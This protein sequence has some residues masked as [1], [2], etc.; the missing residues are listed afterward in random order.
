[1][2]EKTRQ[3][4]AE[5]I[6]RRREWGA[7]QG[8]LDQFKRLSYLLEELC[9]DRQ[10]AN[11]VPTS[12]Q[13]TDESMTGHEHTGDEPVLILSVTEKDGEF[14]G[15]LQ[16]ILEQFDRRTAKGVQFSSNIGSTESIELE[17]GGHRRNPEIVLSVRSTDAA[18]GRAA[19]ARI[20]DEVDRGV[21]WWARGPAWLRILVSAMIASFVIWLSVG[22]RLNTDN[23]LTFDW[24]SAFQVMPITVLTIALFTMPGFKAMDYFFP[25]FEV[26]GDGVSTTSRRM[27][28]L[29]GLVTTI[30]IAVFVNYIT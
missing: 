14:E 1:M 9:R 8:D 19:F 28:G 21:P 16:T 27:L 10:E 3:F 23:R 6:E 7:W 17:L 26:T 22:L 4:M 30:P 5:S 11:R 13:D 25:K 18:A 2:T 29:L 24:V 20:S 12:S 15:G